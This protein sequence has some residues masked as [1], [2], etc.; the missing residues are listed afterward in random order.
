MYKIITHFILKSCLCGLIIAKIHICISNKRKWVPALRKNIINNFYDLEDLLECSI[1][2]SQLPFISN[3]NLFYE[4]RNI[5]SMDGGMFLNPHRK[6]IKPDL[7]LT[8][9]IWN[10]KKINSMSNI[11]S[12]DINGL[13]HEG[14]NDACIHHK[15]LDKIFI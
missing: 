15:E 11:D 10:N 1:S 13:L 3:G 6:N 4:Y 9:N 7:I 5:K 12:L 14:Y 8:P 2:T